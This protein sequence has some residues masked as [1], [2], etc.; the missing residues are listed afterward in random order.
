MNTRLK[1]IRKS[2]DLN[3]LEFCKPLNISRSHLAGIESGIKKL[4][5]RLIN[6]ICDEYNVNKNWLVNGEGDMFI[7]PLVN[8]KLDPEIEEYVRLVMAVDDETREYIKGLMKKTL[9][10]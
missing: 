6:D 10:K 8:F 4:T 3:Q 2:L 7:D 1:E 9:S 5:D